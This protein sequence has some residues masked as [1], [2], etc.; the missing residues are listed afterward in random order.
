MADIVKTTIT[1]PED[2]LMRAKMAAIQ[3]NKTLSEI[4]REAIAQRIP[5]RTAKREKKKDPMRLAGLFKL[6]VKKEDTFRRK[7]IYDQY[8]KRKMGI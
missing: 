4:I 2:E 5:G 1:I 3:E 6:G 7:D 8:L